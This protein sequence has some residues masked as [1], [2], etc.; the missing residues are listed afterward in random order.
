MD[1]LPALLTLYS[2]DLTEYTLLTWILTLCLQLTIISEFLEF[3]RSHN[4]T[5]THENER[6][7]KADR[8]KYKSIHT[9]I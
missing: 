6:M 1:Y 4:K 5:R 8:E 3:A 7:L 9:F 2:S